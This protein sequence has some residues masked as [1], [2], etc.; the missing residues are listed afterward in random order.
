[1]PHPWSLRVRF[2]TF[3][4]E[5]ECEPRQRPFPPGDTVAPFVSKGAGFAPG[6]AFQTNKGPLCEPY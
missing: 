2:L 5:P 4:R 3:A 6:K 1:V